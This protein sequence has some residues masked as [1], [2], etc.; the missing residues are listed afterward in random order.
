MDH[1]DALCA[2]GGMRH[3]YLDACG[4][5]LYLPVG[6][7]PQC[8]RGGAGK[9]QTGRSRALA[10]SAIYSASHVIFPIVLCI[11]FEYIRFVPVLCTDQTSDKRRTGQRNEEPDLLYL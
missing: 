3:D 11:V 7:I 2:V 6:G 9:R 1:A 8:V 10:E 5:Q 4:C